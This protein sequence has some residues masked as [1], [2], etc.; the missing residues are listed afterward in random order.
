MFGKS[1]GKRAPGMFVEMLR[2]KAENAGG[3]VIEFSTQTTRLSQT[4]HGCGTIHKKKLSERWHICACGVIAQRDLYSA[5]WQL[6][7]KMI[8]WSR[9]WPN[10]LWESRL[11]L[12]QTAAS[13][14]K[15][16]IG[17][18]CLPNVARWRVRTDRL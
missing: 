15:S 2:R 8:D 9:H 10:S 7:L 4:C 16:V 11:P 12:L 14:T 13:R 18:A 17:Q 3:E 6:V 5:F 1:V